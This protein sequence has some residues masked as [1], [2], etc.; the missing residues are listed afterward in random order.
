MNKIKNTGQ[1]Y[2]VLA[3]L[4]YAVSMADGQMTRQEKLKIIEFVEKYWTL[5]IN[6][7]NSQELMYHTLRNLIKKRI[8]ALDSFTVFKNF[9]QKN[10]ALFDNEL[11]THILETCE[12]VAH[13]F[14][15]KNKSE[16]IILHN[17]ALIFNA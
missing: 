5:S 6:G 7:K 10:K 4:F 9:Y 3:N 8:K 1:F 13:A 11:E 14:G 12:N 2:E 15:Q 17:L 16:L